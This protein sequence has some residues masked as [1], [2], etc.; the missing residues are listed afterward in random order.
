MP[1]LDSETFVAAD[2]WELTV[3][4]WD[5]E[6]P[7]CAVLIAVHGM[8]EYSRAFAWPAPTWQAQGLRVYAYDQ[9]GFGGDPE[10]GLWPG[11]EA[12]TADL[13]EFTRLI[14]VRHPGLPL[15][16]L[17]ESMGG[18]VI[19]L[20]AASPERL[21][22][23]GLILVAPAVAPWDSLPWLARAPLWLMAHSVPWLPLTGEGLDLRPTDNLE[24]WRAMSRDPL[25]LKETRVDAIYGLAR[26]M[27]RAAEAAPELK[28]PTLLLYGQKDDFVRD[29]MTEE[30]IAHAPAG[31]LET[32]IYDDGYHWLLRDDGKEVVLD[33]IRDWINDQGAD[34]PSEARVS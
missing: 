23:A 20:A 17:G 29:W 6:E 25:V 30:L 7:A 1:A 18:A 11:A 2:G 21:P 26:L 22:V 4:R 5:P 19:I 13:A 12:L 32:R 9:R 31:L 27:D 10:R 28:D 15:F 16:L 24:A 33:A 8:N 14:A 34:C 3:R